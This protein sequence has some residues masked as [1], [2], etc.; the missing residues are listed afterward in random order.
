MWKLQTEWHPEPVYEFSK[1][2]MKII[3]RFLTQVVAPGTRWGPSNTTFSYT[4]EC[5]AVQICFDIPTKTISV[6]KKK[7]Q[8]NKSRSSK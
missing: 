2:E 7:S 6:V 4:F 8:R 5:D 1:H 3:T